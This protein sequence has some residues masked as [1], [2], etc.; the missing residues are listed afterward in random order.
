MPKSSSLRR[1]LALFALSA[2]FNSQAAGVTTDIVSPT[3]V[4]AVEI[5]QTQ[6]DQKLIEALKDIWAFMDAKKNDSSFNLTT[7]IGLNSRI[8][9]IKSIINN[10]ANSNNYSEGTLL[11]RGETD[12]SPLGASILIAAKARRPDLVQSFIDRG[13]DLHLRTKRG[14]GPMDYII[15]LL[16][17]S[18]DGGEVVSTSK[19]D[20][21][22]MISILKI[23]HNAGLRPEDATALT[24]GS[25]LNIKNYASAIIGNRINDRFPINSLVF[26]SLLFKQG[27]M[28]ETDFNKEIL[29]DR[30]E[31]AGLLN[32]NGITDEMIEKNGGI[33]GTIT[34]DTF[35]DGAKL[36]RLAASSNLHTLA[37]IYKDI[38]GATSVE[39]ALAKIASLNKMTITAEGAL[40][41]P[42]KDLIIDLP[43]SPKNQIGFI[44]VRE[45]ESLRD[46]AQQVK[47]IFYK[48]GLSIDEIV[49]DIANMNALDA[50][51]IDDKSY[52]GSGRSLTFGLTNDNY[53]HIRPVTPPEGINPQRKVDLFVVETSKTLPDGDKKPE[54]LHSVS[55]FR[56][57][58]N[59]G[60]G[61]N[62]KVDTDRFHTLEDSIPFYPSKASN[63]L[64]ILLNTAGAPV[65]D[66]LVFSVSDGLGG[67]GQADSDTL[68]SYLPADNVSYEGTRLMLSFLEKSKPAIFVAVG[69]SRNEEGPYMVS[70][71]AV[72]SPRSVIVGA[73]GQYPV[74]GSGK[75]KIMSPY[76]SHFADIC[77]VLPSHAGNQEEGSSF[78]TPETAAIFRQYN[79]WYGNRLSFEEIMAAGFMSADRDF[80]DYSSPA[81][82][83]AHLSKKK[84]QEDS[85][86]K[87][88]SVIYNTNGGGLPHN[89]HCGAGVINPEQ[90]KKNLDTLV[91]LKRAGQ[92]A[93]GKSF[94]ISAG[95]PQETVRSGEREYIYKLTVP[96]DMTLGHLTFMLPQHLDK[97]GDIVV[98]TPAG[99]EILMPRTINDIVSTQAFAYEDVRAGSIIEIRTTRPL[100]DTAGIMMRGHGP[101]NAIALL[102][103]KLRADGVM[104]EPLKKIEGNNS[105]APS[106]SLPGLRDRPKPN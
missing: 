13:A 94:L 59:S 16:R 39:D 81:L 18:Q 27:L 8:D 32:A 67:L 91:T 43:L 78:A 99:F 83:F 45:N 29:G 17:D 24:K 61:L 7:S 100:G 86:L 106:Q 35:P 26:L 60:Y 23:I 12:L 66:L 77:A 58:V 80:L 2:A 14:W 57:A 38:M 75:A 103:D 53:N 15:A 49:A 56:V 88:N 97:R 71:I 21:A 73:V 28:S 42:D 10:G 9:N 52:L 50:K 96:Q 46:I 3:P 105:T 5:S 102:R 82:A 37:L 63:A 40:K 44:N 74:V 55:T 36:V 69:N 93:T 30:K 47:N 95:T 31:A 62:R 34:D 22:S 87:T 33:L 20:L 92:D 11:L 65:N 68:K 19:D 98:K 89:T 54:T 101:G 25:P 79:E 41:S 1:S 84:P 51:K 64:R 48:K 70:H 72:H 6:L 76:T 104:P 90:W 4:A 85:D